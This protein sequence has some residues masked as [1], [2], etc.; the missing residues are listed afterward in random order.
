SGLISVDGC[1]PA[2]HNEVTERARQWFDGVPNGLDSSRVLEYRDILDRYPALLQAGAVFPDWGYGCMSMDEQSEAA[3]WTPFLEYGIEYFLRTYSRP[4]S[5]RAEQ[6]IAF[7]FGIASHQVSD[8]QWHSLSGLRDGFMQV[9]A[10]STFN[11]EFSRAHD[12]LD[13]GGDFAMA[14]MDD[15]RYILDRWTVPID[16]VIRIYADMGFGVEKWR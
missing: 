15:L 12:V 13:V 2:V 1:G 4:Y 5:M 14:H 3:H 7:M 6:L 9:L 8:E 16:D 11:G 10:N